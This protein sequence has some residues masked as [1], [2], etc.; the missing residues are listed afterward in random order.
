MSTSDNLDPLVFFEVRDPEGSKFPSLEALKQAVKRRKVVLYGKITCDHVQAWKKN[1]VPLPYSGEIAE[2][3]DGTYT[4]F[5][6]AVLGAIPLTIS[7]DKNKRRRM[8][9]R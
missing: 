5:I 3:P 6:D 7:T 4:V 9:V 2:A 8:T 1:K